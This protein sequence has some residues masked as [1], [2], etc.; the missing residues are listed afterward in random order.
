MK[1]YLVMADIDGR[2]VCLCAGLKLWSRNPRLGHWF[3]SRQDAL[4]AIKVA[5]RRFR[6]DVV[7]RVRIKTLHPELDTSRDARRV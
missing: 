7:T 4:D 1:Y 2:S 5:K 3:S 6:S